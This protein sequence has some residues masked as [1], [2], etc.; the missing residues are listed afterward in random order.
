MEDYPGVSLFGLNQYV[1]LHGPVPN[2]IFGRP[3]EAPTGPH[4]HL[5]VLNHKMRDEFVPHGVQL[6]WL[7]DPMTRLM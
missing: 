3:Q 1:R 2:P 5:R 6:A 7:V 4:S